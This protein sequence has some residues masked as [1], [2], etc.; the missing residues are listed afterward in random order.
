MNYLA[1]SR[2]VSNGAS[3]MPS[4]Q[5]E[6]L[7]MELGVLSLAPLEGNVA[8]NLPFAPMATHRVNVEPIRPELAAPEVFLDGGHP[9]KD[10]AGGETLDHPDQFR[11]TVRRDCLHEEV[12]VVPVRADLQKGDLVPRRDLQTDVPE[13]G[14]H[15][16]REDRP[17]VFR[18]TDQVIQQHGHIVAAMD[19]LAHPRSLSHRPD[20]ASRGVSTL[21][22]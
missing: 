7:R 12:H 17:P 19:V 3:W 18:R 15:F 8:S 14:V 11:R 22:E 13:H 5:S 9:A 4:E 16:R 10:L 1:A 20:A 6:L 21:K 2:E